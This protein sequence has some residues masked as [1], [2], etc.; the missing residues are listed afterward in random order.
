[1]RTVQT[2]RANS[3]ITSLLQFSHELIQC[4]DSLLLSRFQIGVSQFRV[5][6]V[7]KQQP[8]CT[9][10]QLAHK[11]AQTEA[12]V[13]RQVKILETNRLITVHRRPDDKRA[14]SLLLTPRGKTQVDSAQALLN[15]QSQTILDSITSYS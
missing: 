14:R 9:Q 7:L 5:L 11:L 10:K 6:E 13:S 15:E 8:R 2:R 3:P 1:M 4:V 12:S